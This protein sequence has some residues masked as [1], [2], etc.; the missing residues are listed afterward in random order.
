MDAANTAFGEIAPKVQRIIA[1]SLSRPVEDVGLDVRL[2]APELAMDS[3]AFIKLNVILEETFEITLPDFV[4][5]AAP[6]TSGAVSGA[7]SGAA[8][9]SSAP[10]PRSVRDVV[11]LIAERVALAQASA[12]GAR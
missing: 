11:A 2:D 8:S 3:L 6:G 10:Q 7:V 9:G 12:G 4:P 1:Q 5:D